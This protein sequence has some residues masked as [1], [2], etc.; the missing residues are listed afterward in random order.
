[1]KTH[2]NAKTCTGVFTAAVRCQGVWHPGQSPGEVALPGSL[3]PHSNGS[4]QKTYQGITYNLQRGLASPPVSAWGA[5]APRRTCKQP[6]CLSTG[7]STLHAGECYSAIKTKQLLIR[8]TSWVDL[9]GI[10]LSEKAHLKR[11]HMTE[12]EICSTDQ[13]VVGGGVETEGRYKKEARG[14]LVTELFCI[15]TVNGDHTNLN[16]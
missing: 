14:L 3:C 2:I 10:M 5:R 9:C 8:T 11:S 4:S 1:M 12:V 13:W 16:I 7:Q 6:E 15:L